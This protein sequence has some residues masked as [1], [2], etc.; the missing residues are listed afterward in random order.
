MGS[1]FLISRLRTSLLT[2]QME[3]SIAPL[4]LGLP[5]WQTGNQFVKY[6]LLP[7][8]L[9]LPHLHHYLNM[10]ILSPIF[11]I[12]LLVINIVAWLILSGYPVV[13]MVI[14][15]IVLLVAMLL[16]VWI[17]RARLLSAFRLALSV[18]LP[19]F[20]L[21]EIIIGCLAPSQFQDNWSIIVNLCLIC[22]EWLMI[23][24]VVKRSDKSLIQR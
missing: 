12:L 4:S 15:S 7:L 11:Y 13:N 20:T 8:W 14:N 10:K 2:S 5:A 21:I 17:N 19:L 6:Q 23:Y 16:A 9:T 18:T 22:F 1:K 24:I 3:L